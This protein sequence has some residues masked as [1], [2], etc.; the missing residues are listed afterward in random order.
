[1]PLGPV[2][3]V[4]SDLCQCWPPS[5]PSKGARM[6]APSSFLVHHR[7]SWRGDSHGRDRTYSSPQEPPEEGPHHARRVETYS[8]ADGRGPDFPLVLASSCLELERSGSTIPTRHPPVP[9][10]SA[11]AAAQRAQAPGATALL[12]GRWRLAAVK[13]GR[14]A[15][16]RIGQGLKPPPRMPSQDRV[17]AWSLRGHLPHAARPSLSQAAHVAASRGFTRGS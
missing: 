7:R 9:P 16:C 12:R 13:H 8:L 11:V 1:M 5:G 4:F 10:A 17:R 15:M 3:C 2:H 14:S 6:G